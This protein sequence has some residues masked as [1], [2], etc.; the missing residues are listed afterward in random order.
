MFVCSYAMISWLDKLIQFKLKECFK[1]V[2]V[3][4]ALLGCMQAYTPPLW[5]PGMHD[6]ILSQVHLYM[7]FNGKR[8]CKGNK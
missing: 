8:A 2:H 7:T 6:I 4:N 3:L 1:L 5:Y